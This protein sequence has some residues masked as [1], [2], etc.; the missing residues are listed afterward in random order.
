MTILFSNNASSTIAGS[1][2]PTDTTVNL[3]AGT[4]IEFPN[5]LNPGDFFVATFYDQATKTT[6]EIVHV[7][8]RTTDTCTIVRAQEGTT[9]KA[10]NA[11]DIFANLITAGTLA[12]FNQSTAPAASTTDVYTGIDTSVNVN[13]IVANTTPVPASYQIGMQFNIKMLNTKF[14]P[15]TSAGPPP[16]LGA[17]M[18]QLNGTT[19]IAVKRTDGSD[20][21]GSELVGGDEYIFV[22]NGTNFTSTIMNVP[23][24]PPQ[25]VFYVNGTYGNDYNSGLS[26]NGTSTTAAFK[27]PQGAINRIKERYISTTAITVRVAD[28]TYTSGWADSEN[29]ISSWY[30]VGNTSNPQNVIIDATSLVSASYQP[31]S[32]PGCC[33][34]CSGCA[35]MTVSGFTFKS[36]IFNLQCVGATLSASN[37]N[38]TGGLNT[39]GCIV[40]AGGGIHLSGPNQYSSIVNING[41]MTAQTS[42][43]IQMGGHNEYSTAPFSLTLVGAPTVNNGF[44][45]GVSSGVVGVDNTQATFSG[46]L[47][48][49]QY[50]A[51][52]G[53]GIVFQGATNIFPGDQP[54]I[55]QSP[56]WIAG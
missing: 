35:I 55:I 19:G 48:G 54:G 9:A 24:R 22:Y 12:S 26:D 51:A 41:I 13:L 32:T 44:A 2:A 30:F 47:H 43:V 10:W 34:S 4:G 50:L 15:V 11:G 56:G 27:S 23:Q 21:V 20:F 46:V 5:P 42:G 3:A 1:I 7:T 14:P 29:Y 33:V 16:V 28:G 36:Q 18:M 53:G 39:G 17:I 38:Y 49:P 45:E 31:N 8:S 25:T 40:A 37:N 6:N 52:T